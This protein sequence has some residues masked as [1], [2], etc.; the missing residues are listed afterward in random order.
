MRD[1]RQSADSELVHQVVRGERP[2]S[3]LTGV[4]VEIHSDGHGYE[5]KYS[6]DMFVIPEIADLARGFRSYEG[7]T[8]DL[9]AWASILLAG[10]AFLDL[11]ALESREAGDALIEGLWDA[12]EEGDVTDRTKK[13]IHRFTT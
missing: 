4:G 11:G 1:S 7:R 13:V 5:V 10:S 6:G 9:R 8:E 3:D 2:W 12:S